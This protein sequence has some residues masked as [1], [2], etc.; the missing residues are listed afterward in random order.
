MSG[1][2]PS[3]KYV[4]SAKYAGGGGGSPFQSIRQLADGVYAPV[5]KIEVFAE[6][7][8]ITGVHII[9]ADGTAS[10]MHGNRTSHYSKFEFEAGE[11]VT[12]ATIWPTDHK[13][14]SYPARLVL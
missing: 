3:S 9:F 12:K 4:T 14:R 2:W 1:G 7:W 5:S 6:D 8:K 10:Q 13:D 11:L